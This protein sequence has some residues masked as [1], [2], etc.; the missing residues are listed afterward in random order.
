MY[1]IRLP[2]RDRQDRDDTLSVDLNQNDEFSAQRR[3]KVIALIVSGCLI[4][5]M[6]IV[7]A[8]MFYTKAEANES[9]AS[10]QLET[11]KELS[12]DMA[13]S[14][15]SIAGL[16][17]QSSMLRKIAIVSV[18]ALLVVAIVV[19]VILFNMSSSHVESSIKD[20]SFENETEQEKEEEV[21]VMEKEKPNK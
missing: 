4:L 9:T 11:R 19:A 5:L 18:P 21:V 3:K 20:F 16:W 10:L 7:M 13:G 2:T 12:K 6:T 14:T 17:N 15:K 8:V 1:E